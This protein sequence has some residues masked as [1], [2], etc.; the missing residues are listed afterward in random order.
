[1]A[2][3]IMNNLMTF[4]YEQIVLTRRTQDTIL[5]SEFINYF[6]LSVLVRII[7]FMTV[8]WRLPGGNGLGG[9]DP[10][11][12]DHNPATANRNPT[13]MSYFTSTPNI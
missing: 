13:N 9:I 1:M 4:E 2:N 6:R 7:I 12:Q 8:V 11:Y 3:A 10:A 5:E